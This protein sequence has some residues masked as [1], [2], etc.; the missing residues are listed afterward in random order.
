MKLKGISYFTFPTLMI[1]F[2]YNQN[3]G[4]PRK[5]PFFFIQGELFFNIITN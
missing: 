2:K 5:L 1:Y 3:Y 4:V